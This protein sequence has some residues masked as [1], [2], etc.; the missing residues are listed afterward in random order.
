MTPEKVAITIINETLKGKKEIYPGIAKMANFMNKVLPK[1]IAEI[2]NA[3][4]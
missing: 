2:I 4:N 3:P 1:K